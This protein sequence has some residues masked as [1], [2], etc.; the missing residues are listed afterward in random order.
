MADTVSWIDPAGAETVLTN[1]AQVKHLKG[2]DNRYM[3]PVAYVE[4]EVPFQHGSRLRE[5][6]FR[7]RETAQPILVEGT[8][9][10]LVRAKLRSLLSALN[11]VRGDGRLK[12]V[13]HDGTARELVCRYSGGMEVEER[14][15]T[16]GRLWQ[17]A[18]PVFHASDPFWYDVAY[19]TVSLGVGTTAVNNTGDVDAWPEWTINGPFSS[20]TITNNTTGKTIA[21]TVSVASGE[22]V[23]IDTRPGRKTVKRNDGTNLYPYLSAASF[24]WPLIPGSNSVVIA[25]VAITLNYKRRWLTI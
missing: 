15:G 10:A 12:V 19:T 5:V 23:T 9:P 4:E 13:S 18:V 20:V 2:Q 17:A 24:L 8:S 21:L 14:K 1:Q 25:G 16:K 6:R 22:T 11:P 7:P 3:P